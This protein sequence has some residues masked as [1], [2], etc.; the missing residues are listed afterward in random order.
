MNIPTAV[1]ENTIAVS[2]IVLRVFRLDDG[3]KVIHA[4]DMATLVKAWDDGR[5]PL[6]T[7]AEID[8]I[9]RYLKRGTDA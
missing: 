6:P 3:R 5:A 2:G 8:A 7:R 9:S 1:S 4:D